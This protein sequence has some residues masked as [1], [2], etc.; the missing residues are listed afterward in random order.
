MKIK[1]FSRFKFSKVGVFLIIFAI[2]FFVFLPFGLKVLFAQA[3]EG[4]ISA[5]G[6]VIT[7]PGAYTLSQNLSCSGD[8]AAGNYAI[9]IE[10][11]NV[12]LDCQG[13]S[14]NCSEGYSYA[15]YGINARGLTIKNC[16]IS[17]TRRGIEV[18]DFSSVYGNT[19]NT[20]DIALWAGPASIIYSNTITVSGTIETAG[21]ISGD[22]AQIY[23]NTITAAGY[24]I[25]FGGKGNKIY[26]NNIT[27]KGSYEVAGALFVYGV[28]YN[29]EIY[30]NIGSQSELYLYGSYNN[31][32]N[33]TLKKITVLV[34]NY[35]TDNYGCA[36]SLSAGCEDCTTYNNHINECADANC[37]NYCPG[38]D[39]APPN[40]S[41]F[42]VDG[43][44]ISFTTCDSS[45][46]IAWTVSDSGGS[47]LARIEV[48]RN[49]N[50]AGWAKVHGEALS[51]NG[52]LSGSWTETVEPGSHQYSLKV[53]DNNGNCVFENNQP[54]SGSGS[55][56]TA[57]VL[58]VPAAP[59]NLQCLASTDDSITL[60]W[61]DNSSNES[62][63]KI[64]R[65][66]LSEANVIHTTA[67]NETSWTDSNRACY[68]GYPYWVKATNL[69]GDSAAVYRW[70]STTHLT[71]KTFT[72]SIS[73][74]SQAVQKGG[75]T[76][77]TVNLD[78]INN[79]SSPV[80]SFSVSGLPAGAT[81]SFSPP[82]CTPT[83]SSQMTVSTQS[84]TPLGSYNLTVSANGG[85]AYRSASAVLS[86]T[87]G[88]APDLLV[89]SISWLPLSPAAGET[90][91]FT[92][93]LRNQG[94]SGSGSSVTKY[95]L[96]DQYVDEDGNI[97][98]GPGES[99]QETFSWRASCGHTHQVKA[100]ADAN[101][102]VNE[103]NETNNEKIETITVQNCPPNA[104]TL[105]GPT[106]GV[107]N[108]SYS[109]SAQA[110]DPDNDNVR[111]NFD[112]DDSSSYTTN[113]VPSGTIQTV[114]HSWSEPGLYN[115]CVTAADNQAWS[116]PTCRTINIGVGEGESGPK[117]SFDF[118]LERETERTIR[119]IDKST[120]IDGVI[121]GWLWNFGDGESCLP[122]CNEN[123]F[124][125][126][127]QNPVHTFA[128]GAASQWWDSSWQYRRKIVF[129]NT[130][131][132][133]LTNAP[134]LVKLTSA[135]FDFSHAKPNGEDVRFVDSDNQT[136][137]NH[138]IELWDQAAQIAYLWVKVPQI[139]P[140]SATD[141]IYLYFGNPSAEAKDSAW[142]R[143]TWDDNFVAVYHLSEKSGAV[144]DSKNGYDGTILG[145]VVQNSEGKIGLGY[146]FTSGAVSLNNYASKAPTAP[147]TMEMWVKRTFAD[148]ESSD[149]GLGGSWANDNNNWLLEWRGA[150]KEFWVW[151]KGG[152]TLSLSSVKKELIPQGVWTY[153]VGAWPNGGQNNAYTDGVWRV[154]SWPPAGAWQGTPSSWFIGAPAFAGST[155]WRGY[156]D[157][158]R[159]SKVQRSSDWISFQYCSM[160]GACLSYGLE[161]AGQI[162]SFDVSLNVTDNKGLVDA[163]TT[164]VNLL[165]APLCPLNSP[166]QATN[167]SKIEGDCCNSPSF[168]FSWV[169]VDANGDRESKFQFQVDDASDFSSP[170]INRTYEGL[171][172][173]SG[174]ENSQVVLISP[175]EE[176]D[177]IT[178]NK[179][180]YWRV[181]VWDAQ[182]ADSGWVNGGQ[183]KPATHQYPLADF[184]W[185]PEYPAVDEEVKFQ[186]KSQA[187][188]GFSIAS[189][190]WTFENGNPA[191]SVEKN[192]KV[193][194]SSPGAKTVTLTVTDSAGYS[195]SV[196]YEVR[197]GSTLPHWKEVAP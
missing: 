108:V 187:F 170:A 130:S 89:E 197:V 6:T 106:S 21:I 78:S 122:N 141:F 124:S 144:R 33:N 190:A 179:T 127:N 159:F 49:S 31:V 43:H 3:E 90:V 77:Y 82:I 177:K 27:P 169:Y 158:V 114:P 181:K 92:V 48:W 42:S 118:C 171:S 137:L 1:N 163:T 191:S 132:A 59:T 61:N 39:A 145:S 194:F 107:V 30:N 88:Q 36:N 50:N 148:N 138:E 140:Y 116:A 115:I 109:F 18:G 147:G 34:P 117:A 178:Y 102:Q 175:D 146:N 56:I 120:D 46:T 22:G 68:T 93:T 85:G 176:T 76:T 188:G 14:I 183:F 173:P 26:S 193:K 174:T 101:S 126:T 160:T 103:S 72:M 186:D 136:L 150:N 62:G 84:S 185:Q 113:Y 142:A 161:E 73:P 20:A 94:D 195:C 166:P 104:P 112:W 79:F 58:T 52:P 129:D 192:P 5:C 16:R 65:D 182:G 64:Y 60:G 111:Y 74:S 35:S 152:G 7:Q 168:H 71:C 44:T 11:N 83:C 156:L 91:T 32:H 139:D 98:L 45:L 86:V 154:A 40:V 28:A 24:A 131:R 13:K 164:K 57:T 37:N 133:A 10:A 23:S 151:V 121:T 55:P 128:G 12:T 153:F 81:A 95:Y 125:G 99:R 134:V 4:T 29:N 105:S 8:Y 165:T 135:N 51:G 162:N 53:F 66:Y 47:G 149:R 2:A 80:D 41:A 196:S 17:S 19:I 9:K 25:T 155:N 184:T 67:A 38:Q 189:Y 87:A 110:T 172:Y 100:V 167:L 143:G 69:C 54:C 75:S 63:F 97:G 123:G 70:C 96:D 15:I 119:F 180:Y 157:E